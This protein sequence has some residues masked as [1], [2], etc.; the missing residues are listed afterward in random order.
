ML[1]FSDLKGLIMAKTNFINTNMDINQIFSK[2]NLFKYFKSISYSIT[3]LLLFEI[4]IIHLIYSNR[5]NYITSEDS[6]IVKEHNVNLELL[7]LVNNCNYIEYDDDIYFSPD[8]EKI[9]VVD[10]RHILHS[11]FNLCFDKN[12][13]TVVYVAD[14]YNNVAKIV[15]DDSNYIKNIAK[16][17]Y[18]NITI[19]LFIFTITYFSYIYYLEKTN[20]VERRTY[21]LEL[22]GK[23]Q[24]TLTESAH[25][26]ML[27]P[28]AVIKT[29]FNDFVKQLYPCKHTG[30]GI[31]EFIINGK[32]ADALTATCVTRNKSY[33]RGVDVIAKNYFNKINLA[34]EQ[35]ESVLMQMS[36]TKHIKYSNGNKSIHEL[37][38][39][40]LYTANSGSVNKLTINM[41]KEDELLLKKYAVKK[42]LNNGNVLNI[43]NNHITNSRDAKSSVVKIKVS[44]SKSG[45]MDVFIGDNGVGIRDK[46]N[47]IISVDKVFNNGYSTKDQNGNSIV[48]ENTI[49]NKLKDWIYSLFNNN[50]IQTTSF[51]GVGLY[52]NKKILLKAGGDVNLIDTSVNGTVFKITLPIKRT[53]KH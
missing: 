50:N 8:K 15:F 52:I 27:M 24:R 48:V 33:S 28:L 53:E 46:Y 37:L 3:F 44:I 32:N 35:L 36:E 49:L 25:H 23:L 4:W 26:E 43:F 9:E 45:Y 31:C 47:R 41:R 17:V 20:M 18:Y 29:L 39:N 51:R 38:L 21:E 7:C 5:V 12:M 11:I 42:P 34:I 30:N 1:N 2:K 22:E 14:K 19:M 10:N 6:R 13:N 40:A 16:A